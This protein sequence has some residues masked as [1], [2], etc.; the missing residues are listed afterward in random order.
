M[1]TKRGREG[2]NCSVLDWDRGSG[3]QFFWGFWLCRR[4]Y[5]TFFRFSSAK[6]N[7]MAS[8]RSKGKT[9][10][11]NANAMKIKIWNDLIR[12]L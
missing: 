12:K 10:I 1:R 11:R 6:Q 9:F 2:G 5:S 4:L 3:I 7:N 8:S